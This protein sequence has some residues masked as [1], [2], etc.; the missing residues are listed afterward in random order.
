MAFS[1]VNKQFVTP[2]FSSVPACHNE[3]ADLTMSSSTVT[4]TTINTGIVG[5]KWIR[6][7]AILKTLGGIAAGETYVMTIQAGTGAAITGPTQIASARTVML[8][9]DTAIL[10][11]C[12]GWSNAGFQSFAVTLSSSGSSRTGVSDV[13]IDCA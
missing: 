13:L 10:L 3:L 11:D 6:A 2:D 8:T 1:I 5:L 9:G 7:R 4:S 12:F